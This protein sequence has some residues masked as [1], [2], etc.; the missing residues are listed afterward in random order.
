M[1]LCTRCMRRQ[2]AEYLDQPDKALCWACIDRER[3][4]KGQT[5][6]FPELLEDRLPRL[7]WKGTALVVVAWVA[8]LVGLLWWLS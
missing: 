3:L 2:A 6:D 8:L 1:I 7:G 5:Q 4:L